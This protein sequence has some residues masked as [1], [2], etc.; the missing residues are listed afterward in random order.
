[1]LY[2]LV[3]DEARARLSSTRR[4]RAVLRDRARPKQLLPVEFP[5]KRVSSGPRWSWRAGGA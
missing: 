2:P 4:I 1:M 3:L 5:V